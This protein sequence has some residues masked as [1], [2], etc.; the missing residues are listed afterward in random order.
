MAVPVINIAVTTRTNSEE[1]SYIF[2]TKVLKYGIPL[3]EQLIDINT[4]YVVRWCFDLETGSIEIPASCIL[5]FDGG[6]LSNGHVTWNDTKVHN[7]YKYEILKN[8]TESGHK[9]IL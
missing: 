3:Q 6:Q 7:P 5:D 1:Y 2:A 9:I 8:I 4:K